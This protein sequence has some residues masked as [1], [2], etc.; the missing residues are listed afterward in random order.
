MTSSAALCTCSIWELSTLKEDHLLIVLFADNLV[1]LL[2][3]WEQF[4]LI[5]LGW[6]IE[7]A[8]LFVDICRPWFIENVV[9][10]HIRILTEFFRDHRP[11][12]KQLVKKTIFICIE[13][14]KC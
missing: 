2:R 8:W 7:K 5:E 1:G 3:N 10:D 12:C 11:V 9:S 13:G 6:M 4:F 14:S